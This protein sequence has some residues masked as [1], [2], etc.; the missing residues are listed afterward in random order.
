MATKLN[1]GQKHVL[2]LVVA[3]AD[4]QGWAPVSAPV[5][6]LVAYLPKELVLLEAVGEGRGRARLTAEGEALIAAMAWL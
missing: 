3:G 2:K 4:S 5:Y 6:C 1:V